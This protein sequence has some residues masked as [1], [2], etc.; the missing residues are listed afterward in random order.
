VDDDRYARRAQTWIDA[1]RYA[2]LADAALRLAVGVPQALASA[3]SWEGWYEAVGEPLHFVIYWWWLG[4]RSRVA[5]ALL[6]LRHGGDVAF[7]KLRVGGTAGVAVGVVFGVCYLLAFAGT[8]VYHR[9]KLPS[10]GAAAGA[11]VA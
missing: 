10:G 4:D 1:G 7:S 2:A 6:L 8:I 9:R 3:A 5:A 11:P